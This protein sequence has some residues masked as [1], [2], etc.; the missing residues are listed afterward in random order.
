MR[1]GHLHEDRTPNKIL[2]TG[3]DRS[4][5]LCLYH[6]FT[7]MKSQYDRSYRKG[8]SQVSLYL[9]LKTNLCEKHL[10]WKGIW[11]KWKYIK[12]GGTDF[13]VNDFVQRLILIQRQ[14]SNS[15]I[16]YHCLNSQGVVNRSSQTICWYYL[17]LDTML[18][19]TIAT[20]DDFK[21]TGGSSSNED[22][23]SS[24]LVSSSWR[25]TS[26]SVVMETP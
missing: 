19:H 14:K 6:V 4:E 5:L 17:L 20:L 22:S 16:P 3:Q 11:F 10:I 13:H 12:V 15:E 23:L 9:C 24:S 1:K 18:S 25:K 8:Q 21:L 26:S 2:I 7:K